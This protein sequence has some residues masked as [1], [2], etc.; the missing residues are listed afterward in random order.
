MSSFNF[1]VIM[2]NLLLDTFLFFVSYI[3]GPI[4]L[5]GVLWHWQHWLYIVVVQALM[6]DRD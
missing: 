2:L 6:L 3:K 5:F 1:I 4:D